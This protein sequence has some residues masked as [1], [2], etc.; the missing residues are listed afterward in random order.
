M[1]IV[2]HTPC[3]ATQAR[4]S[5]NAASSAAVDV[6]KLGDRRRMRSWLALP[7]PLRIETEAANVLSGS[8][9]E[10]GEIRYLPME[11]DVVE[12]MGKTH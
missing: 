6:R 11:R 8:C 10:N 12:E 1:G 3:A 2:P 4:P 9:F 7:V 5:D